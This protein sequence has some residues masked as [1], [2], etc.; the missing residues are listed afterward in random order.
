MERAKK[1]KKKKRTPFRFFYGK[2]RMDIT[3]FFLVVV[4]L[5]FG[6]IMVFSASYATS[7]N[8]EG[9]S[10]TIVLKQAVFVF[11]GI[12]VMM[13]LSFVDYHVYRRFRWLIYVVCLLLMIYALTFDNQHGARR[14]VYIGN[15]FSFQPSEIMKFALILMYAWLISVNYKRMKEWRHGLAP[16]III[17]IPIVIL[18]GL[19][20]HISGMILMV[21]IG[22]LMLFIGG[23]KL[24]WFLSAGG[25][26]VLGGVGIVILKG[27]GYIQARVT[28]WLDPWSDLQ[29]KGWQTVQSLYAIGSGG[30]FGV[31]LGN[32][33]QKFLYISEPQNDFIFAVICEE[34]GFIGAILIILLFVFLVYTGF[35]IAMK[36][37][38]QFGAMLAVG[39]TLQF[40]LQALLNIAVVTNTIPN[41]GISLPFISA[42][43]TAVVMQLAQVGILLNI[44]RHCADD[45]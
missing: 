35:S 11:G 27:F 36:A 5:S 10:F 34:L 28:A 25:L 7:L 13:V 2:G 40:G 30:L 14:W 23:G 21:G 15:L 6:L 1:T 43:G 16:F 22:F 18:M 42:G 8:E 26:A 19:Q 24:I 29:G 32:S 33:T 38:D 3:L 12:V 17:L 31:G 44:S 41:T 39:L 20:R 9:N 45:V 37:P 4:L